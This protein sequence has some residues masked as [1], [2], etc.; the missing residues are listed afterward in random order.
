MLHNVLLL[1]EKEYALPPGDD[2]YGGAGE[3]TLY[4]GVRHT[5]HHVM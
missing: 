4:H 2:G 5:T 3:E 1:R